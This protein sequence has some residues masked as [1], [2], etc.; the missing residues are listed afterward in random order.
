MLPIL[1][2][3]VFSQP[4]RPVTGEPGRHPG[5]GAGELFPPYEESTRFEVVNPIDVCVE[6][7]LRSQ[8]IEPAYRC[9]DAVFVRRVFL[10]VTGTL[11]DA[12]EVREFLASTRPDKRSELIDDLLDRDTYADYWSLKW[13]DLLRVES[14][15]PIN[16]W[17]NSVQAY[18]HW[19]HA[20]LRKNKAYDDFARELLTSSGSNFRVPPVNFYRAVQGKDPAALAGAVALTFM[21]SRFELWS[22]EDRTNM[23]MFF[24]RV[25]YKATAEWKEEIVYLNPAPF[26]DVNG[27]LPDGRSITICFGQDPRV[28]FAD[29][30]IAEDNPWF[31]RNVVNRAWFWLM[32]RGIIH[33]PDDI[34]GDNPPVNPDLL[35]YLESELVKADYDL[36]HIFRLILNSRVYQQSSIPRSDRPGTEELFA[37]YPVRRLEAEVLIDALCKITGAHESYSSMITEPWAHIPDRYRGIKL[38]DGSI[39]S[40]FLEMFG[41]PSRDTGLALERNDRPD[42]AQRRHLL[43]SSH[44]QTM[45]DR[46]LTGAGSRHRS[47]PKGPGS[48]GRRGR[49]QPS[50]E[51]TYL[52]ILSR[53]PTPSERSVANGHLAASEGDTRQ[54]VADLM[55]ALINT[56]EFLLRH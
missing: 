20:S 26:P 15:F 25:S 39:T 48:R 22:K 10:D 29:W 11:P 1:C 49:Q 3:A 16:L 9:S 2:S 51:E 40:L 43:N 33:E 31:S 34:R 17:P 7:V 30:L 54:A 36:K 6:A 21:G 28:L 8:H 42:D 19:V 44:V 56:K 12:S 13:C 4:Q 37:V 14:E 38:A 5:Q 24:S 45:I 47:L 52:T 50:V 41:R 55:W 46:S 27:R 32:G 35:A 23:A 18:H 53:Y